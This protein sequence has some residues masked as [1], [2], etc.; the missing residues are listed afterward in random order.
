VVLAEITTLGRK[1]ALEATEA[2]S[3]DRFGLPGWSE[4]ELEALSR[5][6]GRIRR[7]NADIVERG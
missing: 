4:K 3:A 7:E 6:L 1:V 2:L 5:Q